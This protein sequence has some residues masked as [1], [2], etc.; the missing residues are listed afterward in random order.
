V[1]DSDFLAA[2]LLFDRPVA[3][4]TLAEWTAQAAQPKPEPQAAQ[5]S[6]LLV[7][8]GAE[9]FGLPAPLVETALTAARIINCPAE[10]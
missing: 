6:A 9:W 1:S 8:A 2:R 5:A 4:E 10:K 3:A 7:R